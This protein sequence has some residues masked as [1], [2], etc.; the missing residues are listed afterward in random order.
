M[1]PQNN[2]NK[3]LEISLCLSIISI[4]ATL[5]INGKIAYNY[6]NASG[7]TRALFGLQE[8]FLFGYQYYVAIL[9]VVALL[10]VIFSI[11]KLE[12]KSK[13]LITLFLSLIAIA[14]VFLRI[15]RLFV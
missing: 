11:N 5:V 7:K 14:I 1:I 13:K 15:W 2:S 3:L 12:K 8:M 6:I 9:G 10:L 4:I